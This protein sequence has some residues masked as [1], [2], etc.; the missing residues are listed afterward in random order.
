MRAFLQATGTRYRVANGKEALEMLRKSG[1]VRRDLN[2]LKPFC[3]I[4]GVTFSMSVTK[5][6]SLIPQYPGMDFRGFVYG[7]S[8]PDMER[9]GGMGRERDGD[10]LKGGGGRG[11]G[12]GRRWIKRRLWGGEKERKGLKRWRGICEFNITLA[13]KFT[14]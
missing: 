13:I 7:V 11:E 9:R 5:W 1:Q 2:Q 8:E 10:G 6:D 12:R 4:E 3:G 14:T